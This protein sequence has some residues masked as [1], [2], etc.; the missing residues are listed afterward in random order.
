MARVLG[1]FDAINAYTNSPHSPHLIR[2]LVETDKN[3]QTH[4]HRRPGPINTYVRFANAEFTWNYTQPTPRNICLWLR[5]GRMVVRLWPMLAAFSTD[6]IKILYNARYVHNHTHKHTH[7]RKM[8]GF[9]VFFFSFYLHTCVLWLETAAGCSSIHDRRLSDFR[10]QRTSHF[11]LIDSHGAAEHIFTADQCI[12]HKS[13]ES[14]QRISF[15]DPPIPTVEWEDSP[16][17]NHLF[18]CILRIM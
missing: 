14:N 16:A 5:F 3:A 2:G 18:P 9:S 13:V 15:Y 7:R 1:H 17:Q 11:K 8:F 10:F 6:E 12:S 4:T